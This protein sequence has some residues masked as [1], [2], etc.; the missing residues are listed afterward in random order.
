[1]AEHSYSAAQAKAHDALLAEATT[2]LQRALQRRD[3]ASDSAHRAA[4]DRGGHY[5]GRRTWGCP[6]RR[7]SPNW[8]GCNR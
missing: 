4:G 8:T 1:M 7:F 2:T 3:A 5:R 6:G